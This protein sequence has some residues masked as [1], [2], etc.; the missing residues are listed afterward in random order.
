MEILV[1]LA[2]FGWI[3]V[4]FL[5]FML[6]PPRR[7]VIAAFLLAWLFLPMAGFKIAGLPDYTKMSATCFGVLLAAAVF[8]ADRLLSFRYRWFDVPVTI[9][10][11]SPFVT[12]VVNGLGAYDG[13]SMVILQVVTWGLPYFIGR[14]YF[15]DLDGVRELALGMVVGGLIYVPLCWFEI[16]MSP[17]LHRMIYGYHQ[18]SFIQQIRFG[19]YRPMVFMQHGLMVAM[20]MALTGLIALWLWRSRT[21]TKVAGMP[22]WLLV[23]CLLLTALLCKSSYAILLMI[24]GIGVLYATTLIRS[25]I[26]IYML[27]CVAP[28]FMAT[29]ATGVWS[30]QWMIDFAEKNFGADRAQSIW[31]RVINDNALAAKAM[32]RPVWGWGGWG[33][34]RDYNELGKTATTDA[35]W[36]ITLGNAGIVGLAGLTLMLLLPILLA[37]H[38][39]P[40][41]TWSYPRVA[42]VIALALVLVLY[43]LDHLMNGMVNP[44]FMLA[45]GSLGSM[46]A[47]A[48]Q[49]LRGGMA[50][51][52]Q[53]QPQH[54]A[55]RYAAAQIRPPGLNLPRPRPMGT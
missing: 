5:L 41:A 7:A 17:Q 9:Y 40:I 46:H 49:H 8:D 15:A 45:T 30:G 34:A 31:T 35:L 55:S 48:T 39:F 14:V 23:P 27:L 21:F 4:V 51:P 19:G 38:D 11:L 42:P 54:Q 32:E 33:R 22:A 20:W 1:S 44:I 25:R 2:L 29:R 3:P 16:R 24:G 6:L 12:S 18:H 53:Q 10:C 43:M 37:M 50:I 47:W 26:F 13:M 52:A 36:I 28:I